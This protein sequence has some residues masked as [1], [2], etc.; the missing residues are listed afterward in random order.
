MTQQQDTTQQDTA[1]Q[2]NTD[3]TAIRGVV[4]DLY[5]AYLDGDRGRLEA[6]IDASGT[7]WDSAVPELRTKADLQ[8]ARRDTPPSGPQ[9]IDLMASDWQIRVWGDT[10]LESHAL[11]AV[12]PGDTPRQYLRCTSVMRRIDG[13]WRFVH[14]HEEVLSGPAMPAGSPAA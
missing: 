5:A 9:P 7:L 12:F 6:H 14:H 8:A 3:V 13:D 2:Q 1:Q 11:V 10:A 4:E